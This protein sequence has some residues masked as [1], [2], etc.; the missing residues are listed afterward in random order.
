MDVGKARHHHLASP[1]HGVGAGKAHG[2]LVARPDRDDAVALD[3]YRSVVVNR[4]VAID[5]DDRRVADQNRHGGPALL[6]ME[7][8]HSDTARQQPASARRVRNV[9][10]TAGGSPA[11]RA[12][13]YHRPKSPPWDT[14]PAV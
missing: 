8:S 3:R 4:V 7:V 10:T 6:V 14:T 2:K 9:A 13:L 5:G 12:L 11:C 1:V